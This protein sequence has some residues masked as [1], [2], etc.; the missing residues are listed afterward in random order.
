[1]FLPLLSVSNYLLKHILEQKYYLSKVT[2][3]VNFAL[4]KL[5][6]QLWEFPII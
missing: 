3:G 1:M 6:S 4:F 5:P 2:M